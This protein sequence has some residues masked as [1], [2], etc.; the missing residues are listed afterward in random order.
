MPSGNKHTKINNYLWLILIMIYL[1]YPHL[2][3]NILFIGI[4]DEYIKTIPIIGA[5]LYL[6][7]SETWFILFSLDYG[8]HTKYLNPDVDTHSNAT[9]LLGIPGKILDWIFPHR[10]P[11]HSILLWGLLFVPLCA[12]VGTFFIGG[13]LA[14]SSHIICDNVSTKVKRTKVYKVVHKV[15]WRCYK[16]NYYLFFNFIIILLLLLILRFVMKI[17]LQQIETIKLENQKLL[18]ETTSKING[19]KKERELK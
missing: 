2:I 16:L 11:T 19:W 8:L 9:K 1:K 10:G 12:I 7:I 4:W 5:F 14:V 17:R 18:D 13:Y 15:F 6:H 3:T